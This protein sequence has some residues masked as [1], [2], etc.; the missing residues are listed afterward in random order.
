MRTRKSNKKKS[1]NFADKYDLGSEDS[2]EEREEIRD[3]DE[4]VD[5][6]EAEGD[7]EDRGAS[8]EREGDDE[9]NVEIGEGKELS[10]DEEANGAQRGHDEDMAVGSDIESEDFSTSASAT[11]PIGRGKLSQR[12]SERG[13]IHEVPSYATDLHQTRVYGGPLKTDTRGTHLL[14]LLYGPQPGH[15]KVIRQIMD[16]W[17]QNQ[18]LPNKHAGT[19]VMQSPWLAEDYEEKQKHWSR[20]WYGKYRAAETDLQRLRRIRPDHVH[21]FKPPM[22]ELVCFLG[23]FNSQKQVRTSYGFGQSISGTGEPLGVTDPNLQQFTPPRG[24]MMDTGGIPLA[25]GWAPLVGHQEQ[26]LAV[27]S[28][29]YSDHEPKDAESPGD[30]PDEKKKGSVQ[31]WSIPCHRTDDSHARL[32]CSLSFDF[33]R[34]K[35]L[36]WCP[37]PPPDD[38]KIGL[39]AILCADGQVRVVE[40]PKTTAGQ[41][42]YGTFGGLAL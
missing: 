16:K 17:F 27:C 40:V 29:P 14:T 34:P 36:Q 18:T 12:T 38:S 32:A 20:T 9:M 37:V 3:V 4:D 10:G 22:D 15:L 19:G 2:S 41:D 11:A 42:N 28:I 5:F 24:W 31:I 6:E 30:D 39:L 8:E 25:I 13:V 7:E 1:F 23:P 26:F 21:M 35:R 33:G